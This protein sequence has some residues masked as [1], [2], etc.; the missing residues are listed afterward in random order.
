MSNGPPL[1]PTTPPP[2]LKLVSPGIDLFGAMVDADGA[3]VVGVVGCDVCVLCD[4][5]T[6]ACEAVARVSECETMSVRMFG[7]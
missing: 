6:A 1:G 4:V 5:V 7:C 3:I 2:S